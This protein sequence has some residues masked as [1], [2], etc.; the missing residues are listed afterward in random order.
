MAFDK[1]AKPT[2]TFGK[3]AEGISSFIKLPIWGYLLQETS[4]YLL[5]ETGDKIV[6]GGLHPSDWGKTS[7]PTVSWVKE[8]KP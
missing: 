8:A 6:I 5:L 7:E 3:I 2:T 1:V 4:D